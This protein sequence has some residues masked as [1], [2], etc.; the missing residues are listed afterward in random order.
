MTDTNKTNLLWKYCDCYVSSI[1]LYFRFLSFNS[2]AVLTVIRILFFGR[3]EHS[4]NGYPANINFQDGICFKK[5]Y[6]LFSLQKLNV[7]ICSIC[8]F[9]QAKSIWLLLI[10]SDL[11]AVK[12]SS[13]ASKTD[14]QK[15]DRKPM[16]SVGLTAERPIS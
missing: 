12:P 9:T 6:K 7:D 10:I 5:L 2:V 3:F 11:D 14:C 8:S 1:S 4:F 15:Q 16:S 13:P